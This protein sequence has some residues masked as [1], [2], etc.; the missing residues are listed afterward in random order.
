MENN[1]ESVNILGV[2]VDKVDLKKSVDLIM[3]WLNSRGKHYV[4][5]PNPEFLLAAQ[6]DNEFKKILNNADLAIPDGSRLGWAAKMQSEKNFFKRLLIFPF[7]IF[8]IKLLMQFDIVTGVDLMEALC[9]ESA[10]KSVTVGFLGGRDAV[11]EKA[12]NC[13][14]KKHQNLKIAFAKAGPTINFDGKDINQYQTNTSLLSDYACDILFVA[15]GHVKQEKWIAKNLD[16]LPV[17]VA[18][19]VGGAFDYLSGSVLRAPG[20]IR[21]LGLEWLFRLILQPWRISRQLKLIKFLF[22]VISS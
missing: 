5:T 8:P 21:K 16:Q 18:I 9:K 3:N 14:Q 4:V 19:G 7:F 11:A 10:D 20:F 22:L 2:R 6:K 13:L 12:A 17:K 1:I 15:F